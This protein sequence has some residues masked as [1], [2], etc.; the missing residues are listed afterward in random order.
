MADTLIGH[1]QLTGHT[2]MH[3]WLRFAWQN[4]QRLAEHAV[5]YVALAADEAALVLDRAVA[6][7]RRQLVIGACLV[8]GA[9]LTGTALLLWVALPGLPEGRA[10]WLAAVP[11]APFLGAALA[12]QCAPLP[13]RGEDFAVLRAQLALDRV[14]WD[15]VMARDRHRTMPGGTP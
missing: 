12:W 1:A 13:D 11:L 6:G 8:V 14:A 15:G 7:C 3:P 2:A 9:L 10:W 4:P 5:A